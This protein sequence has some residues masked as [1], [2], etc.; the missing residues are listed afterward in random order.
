MGAMRRVAGLMC[1]SL[2][3]IG[4]AGV[5]RGFAIASEGE[6]DPA[7]SSAA[8][9][10][11]DRYAAT[12]DLS[13]TT[14]NGPGYI[15]TGN[16]PEYA[17]PS[18]AV[19]DPDRMLT[20][21]GEANGRT[22]HLVQSGVRSDPP[23]P[24]APKEA[25]SIFGYVTVFPGVNLTLVVSGVDLP[26][27][28]LSPLGAGMTLLLDGPNYIRESVTVPK[29]ASLTIDSF[30][31]T[32]DDRLTIPSP[33]GGASASIGSSSGDAG[34]ITINGGTIDVTAHSTGAG[35]GN[36]S[37]GGSGGVVTI[38][39]GVVKVAQFGGAPAIGAGRFCLGAA[40]R[41][42]A[43]SKGAPAIDVADNSCDGTYVNARLDE[44]L[45]STDDTTLVVNQGGRI[46]SLTLPPAFIGFGFSH[47]AAGTQAS[48]VVAMTGGVVLGAIVRTAD[49]SPDIYPTGD[50]VLPVRL[51]TDEPD[52]PVADTVVY[53]LPLTGG[54]GTRWWTVTGAGLI[55][56]AA[57]AVWFGRRDFN[58]SRWKERALDHMA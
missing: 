17:D 36:A 44:P 47:D 29:N 48:Q 50:G 8:I 15:V 51:S 39:G 9:V 12:I 3:A 56:L 49:D 58:V 28:S 13:T 43:V 45:S 7:A 35:I 55:G 53:S 26:M 1:V 23:T 10:E 24:D 30:N 6:V 27:I 57:A 22:Y 40:A 16:T 54:P 5:P 42:T 41:L 46:M 20:F 21:T 19:T 31:A 18:L 4:A 52:D 34:T 37:T 25:T 2:V 33:P 38:N 14:T 11:D 32:D